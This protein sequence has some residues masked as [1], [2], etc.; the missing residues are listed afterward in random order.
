MH[1]R[2]CVHGYH[3]LRVDLLMSGHVANGHTR[4]LV[5]I[6]S[7]ATR[8]DHNQGHS[9]PSTPSTLCTCALLAVYCIS[10]TCEMLATH[11]FTLLMFDSSTACCT[12]H[13]TS[14]CH[15]AWHVWLP[16]TTANVDMEICCRHVGIIMLKFDVEFYIVMYM[17]YFIG[18]SFAIL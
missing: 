9:L 4:L 2:S 1:I 3:G 15:R 17:L 11:L 5:H 18:T 13:A 10:T 16:C 6:Q 8:P 12:C 14:S 7:V